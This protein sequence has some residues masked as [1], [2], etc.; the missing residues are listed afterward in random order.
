M[1]RHPIEQH[2]LIRAQAND[3][4][5]LRVER[6]RIASAKRMHHCVEQPLRFDRA[7]GQLGREAA[8]ATVELSLRGLRR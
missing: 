1:R 2:Q 5:R 3:A 7:G 6:G 8:I 4:A